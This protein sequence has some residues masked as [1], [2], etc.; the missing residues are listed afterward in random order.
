MA[1]RYTE[2]V[3]EYGEPMDV[4]T[5]AFA[6]C[7]QTSDFAGNTVYRQPFAL[8]MSKRASSQA[9][10]ARWL[11]RKSRGVDVI[12]CGEIRPVGYA[13][14]WA[15]IRTRIPYVVYVNGG[16][17][18]REKEKTARSIVKRISG[19]YMLEHASGIVA[20]SA[21]TASLT[22]DLF[23]QLSIDDPPPIAAIDLGTDPR[24]FHPSR[25]TGRLRARWGVGRAPLMITVARLVPHKGQDTGVEALARLHDEFPDLRYVLVGQGHDEKRLRELAVERGVADRVIFAGALTDDELSEAYAT[26]TVYLGLSRLDRGIDVEGFGIAFVEAAASGIPSVAGDSGGVRSAVRS[27]ETGWVVPPTDVTAVVERVATFL[28]S[29]DTRAKFGHAGRR[30]VETHYNWDRVGRETRDFV[31]F[32]VA[33]T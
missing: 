22:R 5:L 17:L 19:R 23:E 26:S 4:S 1:R 8:A 9:S 25:D 30:A 14:G 20:N 16:D 32:C 3:R 12:H 7:E 28:R 21:W 13:V 24:Q 29:A 10:W 27:G 18:L 6:G 31:N 2:L 15:H 33:R 11:V